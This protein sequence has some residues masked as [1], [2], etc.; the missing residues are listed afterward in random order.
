MNVYQITLERKYYNGKRK[1]ELFFVQAKTEENAKRIFL[2]ALVF[3]NPDQ[4]ESV[5]VKV[6]LF[7]FQEQMH[8][9]LLGMLSRGEEE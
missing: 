5:D 3:A 6:R 1:R 4:I 8:M 9:H 2:E 7:N